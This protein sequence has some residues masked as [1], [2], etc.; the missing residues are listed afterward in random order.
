[1]ADYQVELYSVFSARLA[2]LDN[3][4]S[5]DYARKVNAKGALTITL[6]PTYDD[7]LF[8]NGDILPDLRIAVNRRV[9]GGS[10]SLDMN[11]VWLVRSGIRTIDEMGRRFTTLV[12]EDL[13]SLLHRR[14][15]AYS[16]GS[17]QVDK[18]TFA[19]NMAKAIV[20]ENFGSLATDTTRSIA[21]YLTIEADASAAQSIAK[22]FSR[23][24]VM[25]VLQ[26]IAR[27]SFQAGTYLAF[28]IVL[29]SP[30]DTPQFRTYINQRG[31]DRRWPNGISPIIFGIEFGNLAN[32]ERE[33]NHSEE[34]TY[35]YAGGQGEGVARVIG[36]ASDTTRL[37][38]SPLNRLEAFADARTTSDTANVT[39]EADALVRN[40]E[41]RNLFSATIVEVSNTLYGVDFNFGDYVT[42]VFLGESIDC[43]IDAL[44]ISVS[45]SDVNAGL[46]EK[47]DGQLRLEE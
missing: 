33:Y 37:N 35:A 40:G 4:I 46:V 47:I 13:I 34:I 9:G 27:S 10:F 42:A 14:I 23:R 15:A 12:C 17:S 5:L 36:T 16:A 26:E 43:R 3:Y 30:T 45:R 20:R 38:S 32:A 18:S 19:D 7:L 22:A 41:P 24:N 25:P 11:T 6:A 29:D 8:Y 44:H 39:D 28:D 31:I 21:T 2:I 1:M